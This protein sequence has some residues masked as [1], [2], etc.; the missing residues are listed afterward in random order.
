MESGPDAVPRGFRL[1]GMS[2]PP[3]VA[4]GG[5]EGAPRITFPRRDHRSASPLKVHQPPL[6][7]IFLRVRD[8]TMKRTATAHAVPTF[9]LELPS[10]S[11]PSLGEVWASLLNV[12]TSPRLPMRSRTTSPDLALLPSPA[13]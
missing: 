5:A 11:S 2:G 6:D 8:I 7:H 3:V 4:L 1:P 12:H 13:S 10:I 9:C